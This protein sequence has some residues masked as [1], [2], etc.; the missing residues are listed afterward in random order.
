MGTAAR[1]LADSGDRRGA[2]RGELGRPGT[3]RLDDGTVIETVLVDLTRDGCRLHTAAA[4]ARGTTFSIGIAHVGL[5]RARVVW[6][7]PE[8]YGCEFDAPLPA[9]AVTAAFGGSNI[10]PFPNAG[11]FAPPPVARKWSPRARLLLL[12]AGVA[13]PWAAL[14][15]FWFLV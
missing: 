7:G 2:L 5:T 6:H 9:G 10:E 8:G 12:L 13:G 11:Q 14:A 15:L 3:I 1:H 4:I